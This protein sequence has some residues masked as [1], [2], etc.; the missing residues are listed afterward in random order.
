[1]IF[2]PAKSGECSSV[3]A[4]HVSVFD[5]DHPTVSQRWCSIHVNVPMVAEA[6]KSR[7]TGESSFMSL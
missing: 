4:M 5:A 6:V 3:L 7:G 2:N 1:M